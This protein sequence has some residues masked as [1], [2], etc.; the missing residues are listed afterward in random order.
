MYKNS[1]KSWIFGKKILIYNFVIFSENWYFW[2]EFEIFL[3]VCGEVKV[4]RAGGELQWPILLMHHNI[5]P[6]LAFEKMMMTF[7]SFRTVYFSASTTQMYIGQFGFHPP[8]W[9]LWRAHIVDK[10]PQ[11][12]L[13]FKF[14]IF[15]AEM[16]KTWVRIL[17]REMFSIWLE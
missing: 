12:S 2:T 7:K 10:N 3:T 11:K 16:K 1:N 4:R 5:V 9:L 6:L 14:L 8:W 17:P 13:I 15:Y